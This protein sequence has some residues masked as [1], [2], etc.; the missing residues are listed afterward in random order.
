MEQHMGPVDLGLILSGQYNSLNFGAGILAGSILPGS[1]RLVFTGYSPC[2]HGFYISSMG[3]AA[4]V[5]DNLGVN[6]V[7]IMGRASSPSILYL[8]REHAEEIHVEIH[9]VDINSIWKNGRK[10]TYGLMDTVMGRFGDRYE[11]NPRILAT[12]PA[13][14]STDI[15]A[16]V[17]VPVQKKKLTY[18]DTWAGRGGLGSKLFQE[19]GICA[20][21][22]GG[23]FIDED[24][25]DRA[26]ADEWFEQKYQ[27]KLAAKDLESTS[28]Y[29]YEPELETGGTFG[30]NFKTL[31]GKM[32]S[33]NYRSIYWNE[34]DR[35]N[36]HQKL[37]QNH[38]LKQFNDETIA[39]KH[40]RT[41]GEPCA[42]VCKKMWNEYKKDY[43]PYQTMGPLAGVF[44]QRAAEK[45]NHHADTLGFDAISVG[46]VVSWLF[47]C[48]D[49][50]LLK[51]E[52]MGLK[53]VPHWDIGRFD[54]V[55]D[56]MHNAELGIA[57]LDNLSTPGHPVS[58]E[59]G[60]RRLAW[61]LSE[62]FNSDIKDKFVYTSHQRRGWM[63]PNQYWTP[64]ALAPMAIMGKYY[65]YYGF[66]Y[67]PPE[68]LGRINA[69]RFQKELILD[70]LGICR[71]HRQWA[72]EMTP[73]IVKKLFGDHISIQ[74]IVALTSG[75][76]NSRNNSMP[77]E[78]K[79]NADYV[80]T[81]LK[82]QRDVE[83]NN[84]KSLNQWIT[85]FEKDPEKAAMAYWYD[86]HRGMTETLRHL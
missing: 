69:H 4:L 31:K 52:T 36:L 76:I 48:I 20:V 29:R 43:E 64:G 32:L 45:I 66:D 55:N 24:F 13:A 1:N 81:F 41:C 30:V 19:H 11:T 27:K 49:S 57:L 86:M 12:G 23:T 10:G 85:R 61:K 33:F 17:S 59:V 72:E 7:S 38:Y 39:G 26:V 50:G 68:E 42:A 54:V 80:A 37:V 70:N 28:K 18:V 83:G 25:R 3:G 5:F 56:S 22:Y 46:G 35:I 2:W 40:Q 21:I 16:I 6:L 51:P 34:D 73:D 9:P 84:E 65:M 74:K 8:N 60:A 82:R 79:R 14:A 58:L 15:G 53:D 63:V 44:D 75:R 47:D 71:F 62:K 67:V 78:S 77:W